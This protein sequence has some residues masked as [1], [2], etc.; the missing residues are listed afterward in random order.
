MF[1]PSVAGASGFH[2]QPV[3]RWETSLKP[4]PSPVTKREHR[5]HSK[6]SNLGFCG[7]TPLVVRTNPLK[8]LRN[9]LDDWLQV[10]ASTLQLTDL[11][12]RLFS[13]QLELL[14][15]LKTCFRCKNQDTRGKK[16]KCKWSLYIP[17]TVQKKTW[18]RSISSSELSLQL[19]WCCRCRVWSLPRASVSS[20]FT[21]WVSASFCWSSCSRWLSNSSFLSNWWM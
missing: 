9:L 17:S 11:L 18:Y 21:D 10:L 15:T 13:Q 3:D 16:H 8:I 1:R 14:S 5:K 7:Q 4:T 6:H 12:V 20:R 19:S 2:S